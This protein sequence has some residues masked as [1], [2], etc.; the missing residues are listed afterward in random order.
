VT[1]LVNG[2]AVDHFLIAWI[3]LAVVA[4]ADGARFAGG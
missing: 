3:V 1:S 4:A 2:E